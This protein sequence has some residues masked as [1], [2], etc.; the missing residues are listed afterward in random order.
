MYANKTKHNETKAKCRHLL[1]HLVKKWIGPIPHLLGPT[2]GVI[3][4]PDYSDGPTLSPNTS[5]AVYKVR[6][7]LCSESQ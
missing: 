1:C 7:A 2:Q 3:T 4:M 5:A 6:L